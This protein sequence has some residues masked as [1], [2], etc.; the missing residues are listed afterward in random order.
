ML[1]RP[2]LLP[3]CEWQRARP[4]ID[5]AHLPDVLACIGEKALPFFW[6]FAGVCAFDAK[7]LDQL[8]AVLLFARTAERTRGAFEIGREVGDAG[9][10][11]HVDDPFRLE[12]RK[13]KGC[14][15]PDVGI[16]ARIPRG[17]RPTTLESG[18][19]IVWRAVPI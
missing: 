1:E 18:A 9:L 6:I 2:V 4:T 3:F 12:E 14:I 19:K 8:F 7:Q 13:V 11:H 15:I 10:D 16:E 17:A 5:I